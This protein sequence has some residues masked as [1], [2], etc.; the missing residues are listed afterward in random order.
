MTRSFKNAVLHLVSAAVVAAGLCATQAVAA[1]GV[2]SAGECPSAT[3]LSVI[4]QG[5][6]TFA[7]FHESGVTDNATAL[8]E[9]NQAASGLA[10]QRSSYGTAPGG[11][12]CLKESMLKGLYFVGSA[13][14][15]SISE[16]AGG[17]HT[18]G[19]A[20]YD[21]RAFDISVINGVTVDSGNAYYRDVMQSCRNNGASLVLGPG[22]AGHDTHL[23]CQ[24]SA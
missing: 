20:H 24:W 18:A 4:N 12:V 17:S 21:G 15:L 7:N 9:I 2:A 11:S 1:P 5:R 14:R 13:Y 6:T 19:S 23:H 8:K 3:A 22:D 10:A 16:I